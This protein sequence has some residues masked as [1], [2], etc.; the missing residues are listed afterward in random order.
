MYRINYE[1]SWREAISVEVMSECSQLML[2]FYKLGYDL[3]FSAF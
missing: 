3:D 2:T 1:S